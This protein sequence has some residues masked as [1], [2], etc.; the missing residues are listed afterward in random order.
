MAIGSNYISLIPPAI[1]QAL[2]GKLSTTLSSGTV[3]VGNVSNVATAVSAFPIGTIIHSS[4]STPSIGGTWLACNG[5]SVAQATYP[6]LYALIGHA[7]MQYT[8][9]VGSAIGF[10]GGSNT[11]WTGDRWVCSNGSTT[12]AYSTNGTTWTTGAITA[13]TSYAA[14]AATSLVIGYTT[15]TSASISS[16]KGI[17]WGAHTL[18]VAPTTAGRIAPGNST[19]NFLLVNDSS[20]SVYTMANG[21]VVWT[22]TANALPAGATSMTVGAVW[23]DGTRWNIIDNN[24]SVLY[25]TTDASGVGS[26]TSAGTI[27]VTFNG[28]SAG[29]AFNG[30]TT[31]RNAK[32]VSYIYTNMAVPAIQH[33]VLPSTIA[34][35]SSGQFWNGFC[36]CWTSAAAAT[37]LIMYT[38]LT[39]RNWHAPGNLGN[40]NMSNA[41]LGTG[42]VGSNNVCADQA[43]ARIAGY[44]G[45]TAILLTPTAT[46]ASQFSLPNMAGE[47]IRAL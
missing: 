2:D 25:Q 34:A 15:A 1:Q 39:G 46:L 17:T 44:F 8:G 35:A 14:Y 31:V 3:L 40:I 18:P 10:I 28:S 41:S 16:D 43:T 30:N 33:P 5:A 21:G 22:T 26:W 47:Y 12:S 24:S 9:T 36:Y 42:T 7:Y 32:D 38:S 37:G 23:W 13:T 27:F 4:T 29:A 20:R 45:A 6:A 19:S 11:C